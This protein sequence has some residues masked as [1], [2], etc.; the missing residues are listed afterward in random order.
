MTGNALE[1]YDSD[2][3]LKIAD[4]ARQELRAL[5]LTI[6][7]QDSVYTVVSGA[8]GSATMFPVVTVYL[9]RDATANDIAEAEQ[10]AQIVAERGIRV[11][12]HRRL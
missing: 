3:A 4:S 6:T 10:L 5:L 1:G 12:V 2:T 7:D 9:E 8:S 11:S